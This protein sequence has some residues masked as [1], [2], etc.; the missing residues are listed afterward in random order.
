MNSLRGKTSG[1]GLHIFFLGLAWIFAFSLTVPLLPL[2][3]IDP[4]FLQIFLVSG[5]SLLLLALFTWR[6]RNFFIFAVLALILA[7]WFFFFAETP[8][9]ERLAEW[10]ALGTEGMETLNQYA[11][12]VSVAGNPDLVQPTETVLYYQG[13]VTTLITFAVTAFSYVVLGRAKWPWIMILGI[14]GVITANMI[15]GI[16]SHVFWLVPA[17][18][19]VML[20]FVWSNRIE[21]QGSTQ[22]ARHLLQLSLQTGI[23][24]LL[25]TVLAIAITPRLDYWN[26]YSPTLQK[27]TDDVVSLMP[28]NYQDRFEIYNFSIRQA[29]YYPLGDKLGGPLSLTN[30]PMLEIW[31]DPGYFLKGAS[32]NIYN[33]FGWTNEMT[34]PHYRFN[35][36]FNSDEQ[37]RVMSTDFP[38][39]EYLPEDAQELVVDRHSYAIRPLIDNVQVVFADGIPLN[40]STHREEPTDLYFNQA[41][42]VY[43]HDLFEGTHAYWGESIGLQPLIV[44]GLEVSDPAAM[45]VQPTAAEID[46]GMGQLIES[47][48]VLV[49]EDTAFDNYLQLP[50]LPEYKPGGT[51]HDLSEELVRGTRTDYEAVLRLYN[52]LG[53]NPDFTYSTDVSVPPEGSEFVSHFL[54]TREGYCTYYATSLTMMARSAGIPARYVEGFGVAPDAQGRLALGEDLQAIDVETGNL[55]GRPSAILTAR[56]AHAW[57]EVYLRGIGWVPLDPTPGGA[58]G[59]SLPVLHEEEEVPPGELSPTPTPMPKQTGTPTPTPLPEE[60]LSP[61]PTPVISE[62][63]EEPGD[64]GGSG[65]PALLG[66]ILAFLLIIAAAAG[67]GYLYYYSRLQRR[68]TFHNPRFLAAKIR[69]RKD[70]VITYWHQ[71][72]KLLS[73]LSPGHAPRRLSLSAQMEWHLT[74]KPQLRESMQDR[75][76]RTAVLAES[77]YFSKQDPSEAEITELAE[78]FKDVEDL[79]E[80]DLGRGRYLMRRLLVPGSYSVVRRESGAESDRRNS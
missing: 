47:D 79:V 72:L 64:E 32:A 41:G 3:Y 50:D 61:S 8:A 37:K 11:T 66:R 45:A 1:W 71:I 65:L 15:I 13:I 22:S 51:V 21:N 19:I 5:I 31:G 55:E 35:S 16:Q 49:D 12:D 10:F 53:R 70:H 44:P 67:L 7:A 28:Q 20:V 33:G 56:N 58:G 54:S 63:P 52:F 18:I 80:Q 42:L 48:T 69:S 73:L 57:T 40:I 43:A 59:T 74:E 60:K 14:A 38:L 27:L 75:L 62:Q 46:Y 25:A 39:V 36:A 76:R 77:A 6:P 23:P 9:D 68:E 17:A 26:V 78:I 34:N 4:P 30:E 24:L 29:G 2:F